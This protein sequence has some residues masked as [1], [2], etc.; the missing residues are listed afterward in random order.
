VWLERIVFGIGFLAATASWH[1][2]LLFGLRAMGSL[3]GLTLLLA[4]NRLRAL[5][6]WGE[7]DI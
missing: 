2:T 5:H 7:E 6:L 1:R 4:R 3:H